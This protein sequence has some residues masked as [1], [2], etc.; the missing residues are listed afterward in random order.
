MTEH[1]LKIKKMSEKYYSMCIISSQYCGKTYFR[2]FA[3]PQP[4]ALI[5]WINLDHRLRINFTEF[6]FKKFNN[7]ECYHCKIPLANKWCHHEKS[8]GY[9]ALIGMRFEFN[10]CPN[11]KEIPSG[12]DLEKIEIIEPPVIQNGK[13]IKDVAIERKSASHYK[14]D[15]AIFDGNIKLPVILN[16]IGYD[17]EYEKND[18]SLLPFFNE[19]L[20][21]MNDQWSDVYNIHNNDFTQKNECTCNTNHTNLFDLKCSVCFNSIEYSPKVSRRCPKQDYIIPNDSR[22][23]NM[24]VYDTTNGLICK[25]LPTPKYVYPLE[26]H[27][28]NPLTINYKQSH[29][30]KYPDQY[31]LKLN[32]NAFGTRNVL[33]DD[34]VNNS[35][36]FEPAN[37]DGCCITASTIIKNGV[38]VG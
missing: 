15:V 20:N 25:N 7:P 2:F 33:C 10:Q 37:S 22:A 12:W 14:V 3:F 35:Y 13:L 9:D 24:E 21:E 8:D 18:P 28:V 34:C 5:D 23:I 17:Y 38:I 19:I 27:T 36:K 31:E 16:A 11:P 26:K 4:I 6:G 32:H 30:S 1:P 29:N